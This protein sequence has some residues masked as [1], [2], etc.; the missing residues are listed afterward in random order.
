MK[1]LILGELSP[2]AQHLEKMNS[3]GLTPRIVS[4]N[5]SESWI[6][7]AV[8][9]SDFV[10]FNNFDINPYLG[11]MDGVKLA[12]VAATGFSFIDLE[13]V[14]SFD[15]KIANLKNY[16]TNAVVEYLIHAVFQS[17]RK[18][19]SEITKNII[20]G[21]WA[22]TSLRHRE[23]KQCKTGIIGYGRIGK[24][25]G[26]ILEKLGA[27]I[28]VNRKNISLGVSNKDI[29]LVDLPYL[30]KNSDIVLVCCSLNES[31][32]HLLDYSKLSL[33]R[34]DA[35]VISISPNDVFELNDLSKILLENPEI[36]AIL[37]LD[38]LPPNHSLLERTNIKITPHIAFN[39]NET[40]DRRIYEC[41]E[42]VESYIKGK[43]ITLITETLTENAIP[44]PKDNT[45]NEIDVFDELLGLAGS[46]CLSQTLYSFIYL[47]INNVIE[48]NAASIEDIASEL[49]LAERPIKQLLSACSALKIVSKKD[50]KFFI[51]ERYAPYL[52]PSNDNYIGDLIISLVSSSY[53]PWNELSAV[54]KSGSPPVILQS[55]RENSDQWSQVLTKGSNALSKMSAD[56]VLNS[57]TEIKID[58]VLDIGCGPATLTRK[59]LH[60]HKQAQAIL[61]DREK[62][63]DFTRTNFLIPEGLDSRCKLIDQDFNH[64]SF[65]ASQDIVIL[66][67]IIHMLNEDECRS[68]LSGIRAS[69]KTGGHIVLSSFFL[70]D[71]LNNFVFNSHFSLSCFLFSGKGG[72]YS[73]IQIMQFLKE[74]NLKIVEV[75][76]PNNLNSTIIAKK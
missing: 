43:E 46:F 18:E 52:S 60:H 65:P 58:A 62:V 74:I 71:Q 26:N 1:I 64:S 61:I 67:N 3:L 31:T 29:R 21:D 44:A 68:I 19:L 66:S 55:L 4:S 49:K 75:I 27:K 10:I 22:K 69:V 41:I 6:E 23:I 36:N 35:S 56:S 37:D 25:V 20:E 51:S 2:T 12:I 9:N 5:A 30:L 16:A 28:L 11:L 57:F 70:N 39:T 32:R 50:N 7:E 8:S 48:K 73:L 40:I 47:G 59:F 24:E 34:N 13:K 76:N 72:G 15:V 14:K 42:I 17:Q 33:L 38:P 63:L 53:L 54:I 45:S